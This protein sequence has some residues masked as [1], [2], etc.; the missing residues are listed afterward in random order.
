LNIIKQI[1][2]NSFFGTIETDPAYGKYHWDGHRLCNFSCS[3][4]ESKK[5]NGICP[6]CKKPLIIGVDNRVEQLANYE[7]GFK[8][9]NSKPFYKLLPL[10]ELISLAFG[11]PLESKKVWAEYNSLIEKFGDEFNILLKV[12][13]EELLGK[14]INEKIIELILR[15]REEKI[16]VTPGYDGEYGVALMGEI[17]GRLF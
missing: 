7:K 16:K 17:Q 9:K 10:H 4:E 2:E 12:S 3:P 8:S 11:S 1:R 5:L 14:E 6:I 15:N 13:K